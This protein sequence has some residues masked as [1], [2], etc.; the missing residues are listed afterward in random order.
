MKTI[1]KTKTV[2][3]FIENDKDS[4]L[5]SLVCEFDENGYITVT[6]DF[7]TIINENEIDEY[8]KKKINPVIEEIKNFL[9]QNGYKIRSFN[10][11]YDDNIEVRQITY[12]SQIKINKRFNL[13][14]Y[15]GCLSAIF[16]K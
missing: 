9:E 8:F 7:N 1:G 15:K 11:L 14:T 12:E 10:S 3:V 2:S 5:S 16:I 4:N 6:S 13:D